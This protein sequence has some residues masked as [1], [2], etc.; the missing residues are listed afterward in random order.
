VTIAPSFT[1]KGKEEIDLFLKEIESALPHPQEFSPQL[2]EFERWYRNGC[3]QAWQAFG[4]DFSRGPKKLQ[5]REAW[6]QVAPKMATDEGPYLA[7]MSRMAKELQPLATEKNLPSWLQGVYQFQLAKVQGAAGGVTAKA[8]EEGKSLIDKIGKKIG[9]GGETPPP[10]P[11]APKTYQNYQNSLAAIVPVAAST[12]QAQQLVS[13]AFGED[14]A[15][16][17]SPFFAAHDAY[18]NLLTSFGGG[19][20]SDGMFRSLLAGPIDFLWA[21]ARIETA[22]SLQDQWEQTVL[23][24]TKEGGG[25]QTGG[26]LSPEGP[27]GKFIKGPAAPFLGWTAQK[28]YFPKEV[29]GGTIPFEPSLFEFLRLSDATR[30]V[31]TKTNYSVSILGLP[32]DTNPDA[33]QKPQSTHLE[34]QCST[35][36]QNLENFNYRIS[37]TFQWSLES[38]GEV[39]LRIQF[40]NGITLV[41][42]YMGNEAFPDFLHDFP[43][44]QRTFPAEEFPENAADLKDMGVKTVRVRYEFGGDIAAVKKIGSLPGAV[45][46]HVASCWAR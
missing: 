14:P 2:A 8:V 43:T 28:G 29:L 45:P 21:Y 4:A 34:L 30:M 42:K 37:R 15:V 25:K 5:S 7:F 17:K 26:L 36:V 38:C 6:R 27:I 24:G 16:G 19:S 18:T 40:V 12:H 31:A 9:G 20:A 41:K 13:Q 39:T 44:G 23:A 33:R 11:S 46:R 10:Q 35:G 1:R 3:F 22:C 32:T